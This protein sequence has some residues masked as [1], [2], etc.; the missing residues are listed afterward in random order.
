MQ[1]CINAGYVRNSLRVKFKLIFVERLLQSTDPLY[2][3]LP[4]F[5]SKVR[6][7]PSVNAISSCFFCC[8]TG[9]VSGLQHRGHVYPALIDWNKPDTRTD[10]KP[11]AIVK[12]SE[13]FHLVTNLLRNLMRIL[14]ITT[15]EKDTEFVTTQTG[16]S[17]A[18]SNT[19][20]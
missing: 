16:H 9:S 15:L 13:F 7:K 5:D 3:A 6:V 19:I 11:S 12:E 17:V 1:S 20:A 14:S 10:S 2:L 18:T 4:R 8:V